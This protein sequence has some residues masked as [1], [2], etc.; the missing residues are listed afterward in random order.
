MIA[1]T[2]RLPH[3]PSR[4][5]AINTTRLAAA[6]IAIALL[7][8]AP[9]AAALLGDPYL[10]SIATRA[11]IF[12]VAAVSLQLVVGF[13]GLISLG[14]AAFLGIGAYALLIL[15]SFGLGDAAVSI[16]VAIGAAA[17]FAFGTGWIALRTRGAAFIMITLAFGQMAYFVAQSLEAFGGSDGMPLD[18]PA[19]FGTSLA[20]NRITFLLATLT[21]LGAV[22]LLTRMLG[23][24]RFGRALRA[25]RESEL[26]VVASGFNVRRLR[27]IAYTL[28]GGGAGLAGWLLA[29]HA[30]F[31]SPAVMEWRTS[32][33]LLVMVILGGSA[34]P[35][36]AVLGAIALVIGEEALSG[37]TQHWR[38]ILGPL[39][40][41]AVLAGH[42]RRRPA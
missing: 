37:L 3:L 42:R 25:A 21:V 27:L 7:A 17:I 1:T 31:V 23:R 28:G 14:H 11:A 18:R 16:P 12:A 4:R 30:E 35:E 2:D 38:L 34:A 32:G 19:L 8:A 15:S 39:I 40:V 24:S 9:L 5:A 20:A 22:T 13:G 41:L 29:V 36:G 26:R 33:E 6:A 10:V